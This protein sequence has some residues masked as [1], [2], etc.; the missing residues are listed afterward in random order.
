ML[1]ISQLGRRFGLSR[2]TLLYY[3]S[4]GLLS[5]SLRSR[6]NYRLYSRSDVERMELI[7]VYRQVAR[8]TTVGGRYISQHKSPTSLQATIEI[9]KKVP[10]IPE[11]V[12]GRAPRF[13]RHNLVIQLGY[14][15]RDPVYVV[16]RGSDLVIRFR[17][18]TV[19]LS[20]N[21]IEP[22]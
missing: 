17:S 15:T 9:Q 19:Q 4:I 10:L 16:H 1:T 5:P 2:S 3:D 8:V 20:G 22:R 18:Q 21:E 12:C 13:K 14:L 7:D 11:F 6:A